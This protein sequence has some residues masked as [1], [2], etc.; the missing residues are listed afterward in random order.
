MAK[1]IYV[2]VGGASRKVKSMYVGIAGA[3]RKVKKVYVGVGGLPRLAWSGGV[4]KSATSPYI[5]VARSQSGT[6]STASHGIIA[7]GATSNYFMNVVDNVDAYSASLVR[8]VCTPLLEKR[9]VLPSASVGQYA[10]FGGGRGLSG[11]NSAIMNVAD[12]Y[13]DSLVRTHPNMHPS[14]FLDSTGANNDNFAIFAGGGDLSGYNGNTWLFWY[15]ANLSRFFN[16]SGLSSP[17]RKS[18]GTKLGQ[19]ALF[20]GGQHVDSTTYLTVVD[21][22]DNSMVRSTL[23]PFVSGRYD[24]SAAST[25]DY[26]LFIGGRGSHLG[27]DAY[28]SVEVYNKSLVRLP[29]IFLNERRACSASL[30]LKDSVI[31]AGGGLYSAGTDL[32]TVE[33]F[34]NS[35]VRDIA[36]VMLAKR[37]YPQAVK[38]GDYGL[39]SSWSQNN[40]DAYTE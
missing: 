23:T 2:G 3:S 34:D 4:E 31:V 26:A 27:V 37:M 21:A 17:R 6:A 36:P 18:S 32:N 20:G 25:E 30:K 24:H 13:N 9:A 15:D 12:A 28:I 35:L 39:I 11:G 1:G 10:L 19:Y 33:T 8:T 29:Q 5:D 7:G 14:S 38:A 22:F 16:S 40:I